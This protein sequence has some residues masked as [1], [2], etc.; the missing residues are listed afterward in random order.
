MLSQLIADYL[1]NY[2]VLLPCLLLMEAG[3]AT[4]FHWE[5]IR[6]PRGFWIGWQV[7]AFLLVVML[8]VTGAGDIQDLLRFETVFSWEDVNLIPLR[9]ALED[10]RGFV[11]NVVLFLPLGCLLPLLFRQGTGMRDTVLT[12]F[13]LSLLIEVSQLSTFR[14]TD[15]DDLLANT[16]GTLL[17]FLLFRLLLSK[18]RVFQADNQGSWPV[19]HLALLTAAGLFF[20]Q[21]FLGGPIQRVAFSWI[22]GY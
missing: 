1:L 9:W 5:K 22:Y 7:L 12:G 21:M 19:R 8:T 13:L 10:M 15:V 14:A 6:P 11:L 17:G 4:V 3:V 16:L 18:V 2:M 20:F